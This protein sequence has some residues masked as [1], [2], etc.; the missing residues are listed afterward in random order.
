MAA[1][2]GKGA[3]SPVT[4]TPLHRSGVGTKSI[5]N[6]LRPSTGSCHD[7][8]KHGGHHEFEEKEAPKAK[9]RPLK[10]QTSAQDEHKRRLIKVRSVSRRRVGDVSKP[11]KGIPVGET[12]EWKDI[13]AYDAVSADGNKR[14]VNVMKGKNP[15][16]NTTEEEIGVKKQTESL[17][18]KK[19]TESL[20]KKLAKTVRSTLRG[21][22]STNPPQAAN[23]ATKTSPSGGK[24]MAGN[25]TKTVKPPKANKTTPLPVEK[26]DMVLQATASVKQ[27]KKTLYPP[28]QEEHA[29]VIA[30]PSRPIPAHPR[31]KSMSISSRSVRFPFVR[32]PSNNSATFKLRSKSSKAPILPSEEEKPA[33][34]RFR[35]GRAAGEES[36]SGIQLRIRILRRRGSGVS[37]GAAGGGFVVPEVTLRHHK[38]LEKKK[39]RR[40]YNNL[41]EETASKLARSKKSRVK[42]LVGAFETLISKIGK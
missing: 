30:E 7:A 11:A 34:L 6:Y 5:P 14:D 20:N 21:K 16:A 2:T 33:R 38:T 24:N 37:G 42:S 26:K 18:K 25:S 15:F 19:Q 27:G 17:D 41:I 35:K 12:V 10:Q 28:E 22:T 23:G 39:S 36:S 3:K 4:G 8:C 31:A 9:P 29:A 1:M 40:L 32:Q 13:V